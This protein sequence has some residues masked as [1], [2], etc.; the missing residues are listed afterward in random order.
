MTTPSNETILEMIKGIKEEQ[1]PQMRRE[2]ANGLQA[3]HEKMNASIRRLDAHDA[4]IDILEKFSAG[5]MAAL[6]VWRW[7]TGFLAT[8]VGILISIL[9][10]Q[11]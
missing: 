7:I 2:T 1:L 8:L 6:G 4:K 11:K 5:S 3:I 10:L 9:A